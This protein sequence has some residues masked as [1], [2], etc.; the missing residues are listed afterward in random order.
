MEP[1]F[2]EL[3]QDPRFERLRPRLGIQNR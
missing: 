1:I 2:D 3:R